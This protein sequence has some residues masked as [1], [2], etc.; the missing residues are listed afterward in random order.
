MYLV[1]TY[2]LMINVLGMFLNWHTYVIDNE[3]P[4]SQIVITSIPESIT[5]SIC[6]SISLSSKLSWDIAKWKACLF[7]IQ[8][9]LTS[10]P[11]VQRRPLF[12][13]TMELFQSYFFNTDSVL[14]K[15]RQPTYL[16]RRAIVRILNYENAFILA[17]SSVGRKMIIVTNICHILDAEL[18][19]S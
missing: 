13:I 12:S 14:E 1:F 7:K 5:Q 9:N 10:L 18:F 15:E 8:I 17:R 16:P 3:S 6:L 11:L 2:F 4:S 19:S